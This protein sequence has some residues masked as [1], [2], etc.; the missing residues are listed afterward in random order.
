MTL[1]RPKMALPLSL[2][3]LVASF[4]AL[5]PVAAEA[6]TSAIVV[7]TVNLRAGPSTVYPVVA[8]L[9]SRAAIIDRWQDSGSRSTEA[10][11]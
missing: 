3:T 6:A 10:S 7:T 11:C 5:M 2:T 1:K 8:A 4:L 9:P